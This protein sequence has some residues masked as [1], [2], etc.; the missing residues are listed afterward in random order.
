LYVYDCARCGRSA[1][2][3][4]RFLV[5]VSAGIGRAFLEGW[6]VPDCECV[7]LV[8]VES[9]L[10][11]HRERQQL[12]NA[13]VVVMRDYPDVGLRLWEEIGTSWIRR[14]TWKRWERGVEGEGYRAAF[15]GVG[16]LS[17][18]SSGYASTVDSGTPREPVEQVYCTT[19]G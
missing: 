2:R 4:E 19:V 12:L 16:L 11:K 10:G 3:E 1:A 18:M 15:W 6:A 13:V 9:V 7:V 14:T 17:R 8:G 5:D